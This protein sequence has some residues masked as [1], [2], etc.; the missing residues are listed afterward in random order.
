MGDAFSLGCLLRYIFTGVPPQYS[1]DEYISLKEK[2]SP[3]KAVMQCFGK[4]KD[5]QHFRHNFMVPRDMAS[6]I[7]SLSCPN[8]TER[9]SVRECLRQMLTSEEVKSLSFSL[10]TFTFLRT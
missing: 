7:S 5:K 3:L 6:I 4:K 9:A 10:D 1:V 2:F 8:A